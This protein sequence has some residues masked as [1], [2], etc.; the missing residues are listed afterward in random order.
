MQ[1]NL[2]SCLLRMIKRRFALRT[3]LMLWCL[4]LINV[5]TF[6]QLHLVKDIN[7]VPAGTTLFDGDYANQTSVNGTLYFSVHS[8]ELWKSSSAGLTASLV[9]EFDHVANFTDVNG[10]LYFTASDVE[11]G[12]EL[13]KSDGTASGTVLVKDIRPG[14]TGSSITELVNVNGVAYFSAHDGLTGKELWKSDGTAMG[15]VRVKDIMQ[16]VG[17]SNPANLRNVNGTLFFTANNAQQGYELWKSDGTSAGT[18]MVKDIRIGN[19]VS[20][21]PR[22]LTSVNGILFFSAVDDTAIRN[23]WKS[24]GTSAGTVK[25]STDVRDPAMLTNVDG[26]VFFSG[27]DAAHGLELWKSDGSAAGTVLVKDLTPGPGSVVGYATPHLSY[28]TS[29]GNK[30]YFLAATSD[31]DPGY[32]QNLWASDGTEA[33][34]LKLTQ[35]LSFSFV[36]PFITDFNGQAYF[37]GQDQYQDIYRT[38][39]IPG[40]HELFFPHVADGYTSES[41]LTVVGIYMYF[42][43]D[44]KLWK[45]DGVSVNVVTGVG[46]GTADS[47]PTVLTDVNGTLYFCAND[48]A[49]FGL[50]KSN[51]TGGGTTLIHRFID[52][53]QDLTVSGG[54]LYY[55]ARFEEPNEG[56]GGFKIWKTDLATDATTQVTDIH[57][58]EDDWI[59]EL[60]DVNGTLYFAVQQP[61]G[62]GQL[63]KTTGTIAT[64]QHVKTFNTLGN[65]PIMLTHVNGTLFFAAMP[66]EF[67][68]ELWKS[69]GTEAGTVIVKDINPNPDEPSAPTQLINVNNVLYFI[70][71]NG[72]DYEVWKSDGT[73]AATVMLK[74]IRTGDNNHADVN[75]LTNVNGTLYFA[76]V[77]ELDITTGFY[78]RAVWKSD[79]TE[80]GTVKVATFPGTHDAPSIQNRFYILKTVGDDLLVALGF[81]FSDFEL[82]KTDGTEAGTQMI[83]EFTGFQSSTTFK[84]NVVKDDIFYFNAYTTFGGFEAQLWRTDGTTCG[85]FWITNEGR[86][87][88]LTL[89]NNH[90]F[91][92]LTHPA[93]GRELFRLDT[94]EVSGPCS[95]TLARGSEDSGRQPTREQEEILAESGISNYPNPFQSDFVLNISGKEGSTYDVQVS[96]VRGV[97]TREFKHL[98]YNRDY[99]FGG[100]FNPG[101]YIL[102]IRKENTWQTRKVIKTK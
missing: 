35:F 100:D 59:T 98:F 30:L 97:L 28:F 45:T 72:F 27:K 65:P 32:L 23:L 70:G 43:S 102:K 60:T 38:N 6:A 7:T 15:T 39:G 2:P 33:G 58:G 26:T 89:S 76:S 16:V 17:S 49:S 79:G 95:A 40:A 90:I 64:T 78:K 29:V 24:D 75:E 101:L 48:G 96:D 46:I 47:T 85:T 51:G 18:V 34:T 1:K 41:D 8:R 66:N 62:E 84:D 53:I 11:H 86:P 99:I 5:A 67:G 19:K 12:M 91:V 56:T 82:W 88:Y 21:Q 4:M 52:P 22:S 71:Y 80:A 61:S 20:S 81:G 50:W 83:K 36:D 10:T 69:D 42:I 93:Y 94:D 63:W 54:N 68:E 73:V 31:P 3:Q 37:V 77:D 9:K 87:E 74:D 25:V 57:P 55:Y 92:A 14:A 13:W 44:G